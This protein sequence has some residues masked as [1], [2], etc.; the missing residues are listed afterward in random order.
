MTEM[1][2]AQE[3]L[4]S[5]D[6]EKL[7]GTYLYEHPFNYDE[8]PDMWD[9]TVNHIRSKVRTGLS[10]YIDRLRSIEGTI[11]WDEHRGI[12]YIYRHMKQ[13]MHAPDCGL[14]FMDEL[15]E[16]GVE[17]ED[18]AFEF[19]DQATIMG[20]LVADTA[21]TKRH[22]YALMAEVMFQA[23]F[24]GFK[25]ERL[26]EE[27][28]KLEK[29]SREAKENTGRGKSL[30]E[31]L[32]ELGEKYGFVPDRESE[33]EKELHVKIVQADMAYSKHSRDKE[34]VLIIASLRGGDSVC[35]T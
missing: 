22:I 11:P 5:L 29:S 6:T 8:H 33:D 17:C 24:F 23:S 31:F 26:A 1:K 14:C 16:K 18:Y 30:S 20:F 15:M 10:N 13:G 4:R 3:V 7:I 9:M 35:R 32:S 21:L 25:Q 12:L 2:T 28:D 34:L 19:T 27:L